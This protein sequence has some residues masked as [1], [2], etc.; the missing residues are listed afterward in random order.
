[1]Q[2]FWGRVILP[3]M[4]GFDLPYCEECGGARIAHGPEKFSL[5]LDDMIGTFVGSDR[6]RSVERAADRLFERILT[7]ARS[8]AFMERLIAL[9]IAR[10]VPYETKENTRAIALKEGADATRVSLATLTVLGL[11]VT[12]VAKRTYEGGEGLIFFRLIPRPWTRKAPSFYFMDDKARLKTFLKEAGIPCADGGAARTYR[13]ALRI[14]KAIGRPV[15]T[16]PHCGSRGRHTTIDIRTPEELERGFRIAKQLSPRVVV[17]T[18]IKGVVHRV[19]LVGGKPVAIAKREYPYVMGDGTH[20]V[21]NLI[22]IENRNPR[23]DGVFFKPIEITERLTH[24]LDE[25]GLKATDIPAD[26]RKVLVNDKNSRLNGTVTDDITDRVHPENLA[27]FTRIGELLEDPI[28]GVDIML[29]DATR[30]WTEQSEVGVLECNSM[31]YIDV[32]HKVASG[33]AINV[34]ALLWDEVFR[35][36]RR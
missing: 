31:P 1:M 30:P 13:E 21:L 12:H 23:R 27:L 4:K 8:R 14:F 15:I 32:H 11:P 3:R 5:V 16:K 10:L 35:T 33:T 19:T 6:S 24:V 22:E 18:Y 20:T 28:V 29:E 9:G 34:A 17:E 2:P 26:G 25:Q 36:S 7:P